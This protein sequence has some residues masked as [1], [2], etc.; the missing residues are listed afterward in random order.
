M[1]RL[2][3]MSNN[4]NYEPQ[5]THYTFSPLTHLPIFIAYGAWSR[6]DT[7]LSSTLCP[8]IFHYICPS[9]SQKGVC[10]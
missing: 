8:I 3:T 6:E 10:V 2:V 1:E 4:P 5:L 7:V 9:Q